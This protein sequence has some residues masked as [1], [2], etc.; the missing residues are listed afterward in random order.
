LILE[1]AA[2]ARQDGSLSLWTIEGAEVL[3]TFD[4]AGLISRVRD[5]SKIV[6]VPVQ[7]VTL[8][9]LLQ[10]H[11]VDHIDLLV[12]DTEGFDYEVIKMAMADGVPRAR[13]VRFEHL[14]LSTADCNA[15][16]ALLASHGY[17]LLRDGIDTM[18]YRVIPS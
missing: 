10:R 4:R 7:A 1:N 2:L 12:I 9:T 16:A 17:R 14:H 15:C 5:A 13:L 18:A 11:Q 8:A 6:E 3:A